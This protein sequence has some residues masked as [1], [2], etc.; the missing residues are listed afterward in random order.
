[1]EDFNPSLDATSKPTTPR[2]TA[3]KIGG[4]VFTAYAA[5]CM[6]LWMMAA[7]HAINRFYFPKEQSTESAQLVESL[8]SIFMVI[9]IPIPRLSL[10]IA[11]AYSLHLSTLDLALLYLANGALL[12]YLAARTYLW[13]REALGLR[14]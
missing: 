2:R 11:D 13:F 8:G 1:M 7:A 9:S 12:S 10:A 5:L 3:M 6:W 14:K 4:I